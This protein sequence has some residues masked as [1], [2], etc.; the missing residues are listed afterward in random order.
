MV[1]A[2]VTSG[3]KPDAGSKGQARREQILA[4]ATDVLLEEGYAGFSMRGVAARAGVGLSHVQYYFPEPALIV[5]ALLDRFIS[6][7]AGAVMS[8]FRSSSGPVR[9]RLVAALE[10]LLNDDAYRNACSIFMLE[11]A[12]LAARDPQV[13]EAVER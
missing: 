6:Q 10:F 3:K 5:A 9:A 1:K 4:A 8:E 11:V 7:Y 13:S 2:T 12:S